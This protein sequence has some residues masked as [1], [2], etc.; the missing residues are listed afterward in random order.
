MKRSVVSDSLRP[1]GLYSPWNSPGQSTGMGCHFLLQEFFLTQGL[2]PCLLHWQADS[3]PLSHLGSL[4]NMLAFFKAPVEILFPQFSSIV[5][6]LVYCWPQQLFPALD[7]YAI[8]A[9]VSD[10]HPQRRGLFCSGD[11]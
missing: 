2:N 6:W 4:R 5:L 11:L 9:T 7:S 8:K 3:S 10:K 1:H